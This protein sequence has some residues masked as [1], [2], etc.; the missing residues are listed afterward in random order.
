MKLLDNGKTYSSQVKVTADP[1]SKHSAEDRQL[2]FDTSMKIYATLER[3]SDLVDSMLATHA[4]AQELASK[5][6]EA[7]ATRKRLEALADSIDKLRSKIVATKEGGAVTGE[8]RIREQTAEVYGNVTGFEG[9][10]TQTQINRA[11]ALDTELN[12]VIK[13]YDSLM[14]KELPAINPM[15]QKKKLPKIELPASGGESKPAA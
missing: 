11:A 6:P 9:R 5:L 3:M 2:Q 15:L 4:Q 14:K 10:P 8:E 12:G 1:L 7:D 13:D